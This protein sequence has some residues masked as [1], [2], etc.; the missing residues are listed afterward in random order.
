[1][2]VKTLAKI[3]RS[4]VFLGI[5]KENKPIFT[6]TG[7]L[8]EVENVPYLVT[9]KHI[10][11]KDEGDRCVFVNSKRIGIEV[12]H[13]NKMLEQ[14][15]TWKTH[16]DPRVD[17]AI[18]PFPLDMEVDLVE[19]IPEEIYLGDESKIQD[20]VEIF[21]LSF[22]PHINDLSKEQ[23]IIPIV[24]RGSIAKKNY[25]RTFYMDGFAFPGNSGS[26]VFLAPIPIETKDN[27]IKMGGPL[28]LV[29]V[30]SSYLPYEDVSVSQQTGRVKFVSSE[31]TGLA[32]VHSSVL[33][34]EIIKSE[35]FQQQHKKLREKILENRENKKDSPQNSKQKD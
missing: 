33:L 27:F 3:K 28:K 35:D 20:L 11:R 34:E 8:I 5:M 9:A 2:F 22:Q 23:G 10:A 30:I 32:E 26:P 15:V 6:G 14:G 31:N 16:A 24:R 25:N 29:G 7:F 4:V 13:L 21:F 12:K 1:M 17:I 19:F 18:I